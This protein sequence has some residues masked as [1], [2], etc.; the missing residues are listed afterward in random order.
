MSD[1]VMIQDCIEYTPLTQ[2]AYCIQQH[3]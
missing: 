2:D 3:G 1:A